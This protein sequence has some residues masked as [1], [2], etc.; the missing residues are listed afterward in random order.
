MNA[1][2]TRITPAIAA[3][4]VTSRPIP[5]PIPAP[6]AQAAALDRLQLGA[7]INTDAGGGEVVKT[8]SMLSRSPGSALN[9]N[10]LLALCAEYDSGVALV[11]S[12]TAGCPFRDTL[13]DSPIADDESVCLVGS[14]L[15]RAA[16]TKKLGEPSRFAIL[17]H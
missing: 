10:P 15:A 13:T 6:S 7:T 14:L 2:H 12:K 1:D 9:L 11:G 4:P 5:A 3:A 8:G 17:L 16:T